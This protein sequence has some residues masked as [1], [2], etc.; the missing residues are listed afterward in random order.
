ML[1]LY[2]I[3][4]KE[5][6]R[7]CEQLFQYNKQIELHWKIH[8][9]WGN[10]LL[11]DDDISANRLLDGLIKAMI[12]VFTR[13]RLTPMVKEIITTKYYYTTT[14]EIERILEL[15]DWI[16]SGE[17]ADS[18]HIRNSNDPIE[19][20]EAV[21]YTNVNVQKAIHF[22]SIIQFRLQPF[23]ELLT[24][25]VGFAIDEFKREEEHQT[26]I[27]TI[28]EYVRKGGEGYAI[29]H[30]L[31]REPFVFFSNSG[32]LLSRMELR[33]IMQKEPLYMVGL[34][35]EERNL[36]PLVAL[37]PKQIII[38]GNDP[39]EPKTLTIMNVFEERVSL[40]PTNRFPFSMEGLHN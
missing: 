9:E 40:M 22:D 21:M 5:A 25:Y 35:T 4:N 37:K 33:T 29:I 1:E 27:N 26:F 3:S 11:V 31:Q 23:K 7:F 16:F 20:L 18:L 8:E 30:V 24:L 6:I 14:E 13:H 36:S 12:D 10:H 19:M 17:D 32:K 15:T 38:Y 39:S 34:H 2:F 28:R